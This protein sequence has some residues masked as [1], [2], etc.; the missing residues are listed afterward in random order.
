MATKIIQRL[1]A[2]ARDGTTVLLRGGTYDTSTGI[3]DPGDHEWLHELAVGDRDVSLE[4]EFQ[5][6]SE[7]SI[8]IA[9]VDLRGT[10]ISVVAPSERR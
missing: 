1:S 9:Q 5:D 2:E 3:I 6:G 8:S 4:I 7:V 10:S